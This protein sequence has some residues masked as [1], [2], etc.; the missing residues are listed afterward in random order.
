[1]LDVNHIYNMDC[2]DGLRQLDDGCVDMT[3]TSPP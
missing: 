3:V 2:L 1:M